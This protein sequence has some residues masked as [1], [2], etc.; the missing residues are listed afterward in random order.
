MRTLRKP[1][2]RLDGEIGNLK[3]GPGF[4]PENIFFFPEKYIPWIEQGRKFD[5]D[6]LENANV[7]VRMDIRNI[8]PNSRV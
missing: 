8:F 6:L 7:L 3:N 5:G 2:Y 4:F 1:P